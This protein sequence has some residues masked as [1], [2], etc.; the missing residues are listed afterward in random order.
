MEVNNKVK[1][2]AFALVLA[3]AISIGPA[4]N[5]FEPAPADT[6]KPVV[7]AYWD[8]LGNVWTICKGHTKDVHRGDT[9]TQAQ[10]DR[11][12]LQDRIVA[13]QTV[14]RCLPMLTDPD[15]LGGLTDAAFNLGSGVVCSSTLRRDAE[16]G[17]YWG[18]CM[19]LTDA[20]G[21]DGM[22][23]GWTKANGVRL[24]GLVLR[25]IYDRDWCLGHK[26][27]LPTDISP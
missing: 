26:H 22:P 16:A 19:Q 4:I 23:D 27:P 9:A 21:A 3:A 8:S 13:A 17:D 5:Y 24:K 1:G 10:C 7:T 20:T 6:V 12:S 11:Y 2:G 15:Q 18:M 25:R 14:H